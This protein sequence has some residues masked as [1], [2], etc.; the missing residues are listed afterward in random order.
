[1]SVG[2][3][4]EIHTQGVEVGPGREK[5]EAWIDSESGLVWEMGL[6]VLKMAYC[7]NDL[8]W[9]L[10]LGAWVY[11]LGWILIYWARSWRVFYQA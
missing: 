5:E 7:C 11:Y 6:W 8:V 4:N 1:M 3:A 10:E 9:V 2:Q